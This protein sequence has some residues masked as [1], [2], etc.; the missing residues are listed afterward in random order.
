MADEPTVV[1]TPPNT[2]RRIDEVWLFVS[3]DEGGEGAAAAPMMGPGSLVPL[4]AADE[5]RLKSR[6]PIARYLAREAGMTIKLIKMTAR[7]E[8]MEIGP[9]GGT[10]Q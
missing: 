4:I 2:L 9:D 1:L 6:I 5:G 3:S 8:I 10:T 7:T